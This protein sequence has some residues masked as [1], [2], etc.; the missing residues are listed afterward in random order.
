MMEWKRS[1]VAVQQ[2]MGSDCIMNVYDGMEGISGCCSAE[3][4]QGLYNERV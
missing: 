3:D 2:R 1:V 4:G